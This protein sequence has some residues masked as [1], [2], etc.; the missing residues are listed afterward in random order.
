MSRQLSKQISVIS[1]PSM[2]IS[3]FGSSE[4]LNREELIDESTQGI[5]MEESS[6]GKV[7]GSVAVKYFCAGGNWFWI[8]T[9]L[10]SLGLSQLLA[11]AAD[12]WVSVW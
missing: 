10:L 8:F 4:T 7:K 5:G 2:S 11:S 1:I 3:S 6:E 9:I 12:Y